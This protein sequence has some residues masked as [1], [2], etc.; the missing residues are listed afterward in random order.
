MA[1]KK[2]RHMEALSTCTICGIDEENS[3]HAL[4]L[5]PLARQLW[6]AMA[7]CWDV[8]ALLPAEVA[9]ED[10]IFQLLDKATELQ[11][12]QILLIL[13]RAWHVHNEITHHKPPP[14]VH[15]SVSFLQ[16]YAASLSAIKDRPMDDP[17]K[18]K[19]PVVLPC[20]AGAVR[21]GQ[22]RRETLS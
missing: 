8:P 22:S 4:Y 12:M 10:W 5:C 16:S 6:S 14:A 18:G 15:A 20:P 2:K 7:E 13:W 11:R 1:N 21:R 17:C 9:S 19:Q 3:I